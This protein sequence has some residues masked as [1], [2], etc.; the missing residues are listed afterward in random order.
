MSGINILFKEGIENIIEYGDNIEL[1]DGKTREM[2]RFM[3][4]GFGG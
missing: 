4:A 2:A 3:E 1:A